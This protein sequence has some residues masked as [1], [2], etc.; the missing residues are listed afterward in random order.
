MVMI[1]PIGDLVA[2]DHLAVGKHHE[3][4]SGTYTVESVESVDSGRV[5]V[6]LV[7]DDGGDPIDG[8]YDGGLGVGVG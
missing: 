8:V 7:S 2:G 3:I 5:R 6:K 4:P 1:K